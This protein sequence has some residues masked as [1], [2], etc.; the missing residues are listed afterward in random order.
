LIGQQKHPQSQ[1]KTN[2]LTAQL[3]STFERLKN[4][5]TRF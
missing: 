1:N 3:L 2:K 5:T 4:L